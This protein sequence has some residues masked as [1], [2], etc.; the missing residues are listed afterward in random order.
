MTKARE[1]HKP[2][3]GVLEWRM[4]ANGGKNKEAPHQA[5]TA[6][7]ESKD[8]SASFRGQSGVRAAEDVK[9]KDRTPR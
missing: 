7:T 2:A 1:L 3:F 4:S 9:K 5:A 6:Y 8:T